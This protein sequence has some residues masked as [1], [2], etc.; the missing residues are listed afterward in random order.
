MNDTSQ[1]PTDPPPPASTP[2]AST[3]PAD[4]ATDPAPSAKPRLRDRVLGWRGVAAVA[5]AS[6]IM[7][8]VGGVVLG[9]VSAS[10]D[11]E[12]GPGGR[13]FPGQGQ[14]PGDGQ[15]PGQGQMPGQDDGQQGGPGGVPGGMQIPPGTAPQDDVQ[16]DAPSGEDSSGTNS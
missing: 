6:L 11:D 10:A 3:P 4:P 7:G 9:H 12:R 13:Q 8:G 1:L 2:P 16:P 15:F 5:A 14:M